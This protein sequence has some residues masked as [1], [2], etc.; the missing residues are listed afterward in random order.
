MFHHLGKLYHVV[1]SL[2][3]V[4]PGNSEI[5]L[6]YRAA[7][8]QD[9]G[10]ELPF[11]LGEP[12]HQFLQLIIIVGFQVGQIGSYHDELARFAVEEELIVAVAVLHNHRDL[13]HVHM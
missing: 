9:L 12:G 2:A 8:L 6:T 4:D 11:P 7:D 13:F 3:G 10:N 1:I 5:S